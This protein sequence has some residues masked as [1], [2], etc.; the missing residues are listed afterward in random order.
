MALRLVTGPV[1]EPASLDELKAQLRVTGTDE[2]TL[3]EA[4]LVTAREQAE[5][6]TRRA[7]LT[8]TWELTLDRF[9]EGGPL[10]LALPPVQA[11]TSLTYIDN[12]GATQAL[13]T[14]PDVGEPTVLCQVD[15]KSEPGR[16]VP[17]YG[18][19]WPVTRCQPNAVTVQFRCGY[20]N[21]DYDVPY[22]IKQATLV[23]AAKLYEYRE[24]L[25][26]GPLSAVP[27]TTEEALLWPYRVLGF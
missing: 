10:T 3:L 21:T 1:L 9:P 19:C 5:A 14:T 23:L 8:Q 18:Q 7:F 6:F 24:G 15:L 26:E 27:S 12:A 17:L 16:L 13:I 22:P 11:V 2:D 25:S 4:L 20:G